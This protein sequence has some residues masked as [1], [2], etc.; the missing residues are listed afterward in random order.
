M[1]DGECIRMQTQWTNTYFSNAYRWPK[2]GVLY[3]EKGPRERYRTTKCPPRN[4][5]ASFVGLQQTGVIG[6]GQWRFV[7]WAQ[8]KKHIRFC[9]ETQ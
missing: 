7:V 6:L 1:V 4:Y 2:N 3:L 5:F 9:F 8:L